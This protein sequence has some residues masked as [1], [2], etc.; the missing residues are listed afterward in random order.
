MLRVFQTAS[1]L[2]LGFRLLKFFCTPVGFVVL[3]VWAISTFVLEPKHQPHEEY[4]RL[5]DAGLEEA[6]H[7]PTYVNLT[8]KNMY[9]HSF[10]ATNVECMVDGPHGEWLL[11][12]IPSKHQYSIAETD[13][14]PE[15]E[16]GGVIV[17]GVYYNLGIAQAAR[18]AV[19]YDVIGRQPIF[20]DDQGD[21][22]IW[23]KMTDNHYH[24]T[25]MWR[26]NTPKVW[27]LSKRDIDRV[28][29]RTPVTA[30]AEHASK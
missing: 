20:S 15:H 16:K 12:L 27:D 24:A 5:D 29:Y 26:N 17:E 4:L 10:D 14:S 30:S 11:T 1:V 2:F 25:V 8:F 21:K 23:C 18:H 13:S 19:Q 9:E 7:G 22:L 3:V 28:D 6:S